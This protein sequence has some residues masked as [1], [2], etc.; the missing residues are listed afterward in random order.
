MDLLLAAVLPV[1]SRE[2]R[3]VAAS[4]I[5]VKRLV[6]QLLRLDGRWCVRSNRRSPVSCAERLKRSTS[7]RTLVMTGG[8]ATHA[9]SSQ[10]G[11]SAPRWH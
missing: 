5:V 10:V 9:P 7:A 4:S 3:R 6:W 2:I 8:S 1:P 11:P